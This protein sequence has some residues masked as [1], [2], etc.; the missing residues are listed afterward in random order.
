YGEGHTDTLA[1]I[2]ITDGTMKLVWAKTQDVVE[3]AIYDAKNAGMGADEKFTPGEMIEVMGSALF[4]ALEGVTLSYTAE[5]S[6]MDVASAMSGDGTVT[7]TAKGE[8]DAMITITAHASMP[9]SVM[10]NDQSDPREASIT[11]PVEVGLEALSF[12]LKGPEDMHIVEGGMAH[13]NGTMGVAMLTVT[14]N[15]AVTMDTEVM[16]MR[17]RAMSTA[18]DSDYMPVPTMITIET[19]EMMGSVEITATEDDMAE[20][21]EELVLYAMVGDMTVEGEVKLYIWD[22]AVPALPIIAQLLLAAFL[23]FGGYRRYRRR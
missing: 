22:A 20:D 18:I 13:A 23:A 2:T 3:D 5:S 16:I 9:S 7:V 6:D 8:G 10:I 14:A 17:D 21:M 19:G 15:R 4:N 1:A 11:F 12:M